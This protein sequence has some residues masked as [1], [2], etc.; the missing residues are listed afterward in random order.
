MNEE[1]DVPE[2]EIEAE[3]RLAIVRMPSPTLAQGIVSG[4]HE[5]ADYVRFLQQ[6]LSY[7]AVLRSLGLEIVKLPS[8]P[9]YPD[10]HFVE[11]TAVI[12]PEVAVITRPGA[13]QRR[14]ETEE[15]RDAVAELRPLATIEEP[16]TLEG[17]DVLRIGRQV[18]VGLS[19]RTNK[20]GAE[21]LAGILEPFGYGVRTVAVKN[22]LHLKS[23]VTY[24]GRD[25]LLLTR[26]W[27]THKAFAR[28]EK[29]VVPDEE[30]QAANALLAHSRLLV[31]E[32]YPQTSD[33][34]RE[35]GFDIL[36]I[37]VTEPHKMDGGMTCMSLC[38][39]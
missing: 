15:M 32:G 2:P 28:F 26:K 16:G 22:S 7:T 18:F 8:L 39:Q 23:E 20:A 21:Q 14:G 3:Y 33:L 25:T 17:G 12:T 31:A 19:K 29:I 11:D 4:A 6:H 27:A 13:E 5:P 10:A 30:A 36:E 24:I 1:V 37:V 34:L 35:A 9:E 38:F